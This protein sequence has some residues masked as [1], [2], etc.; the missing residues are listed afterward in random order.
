[1][2]SDRTFDRAQG[3]LGIGLAPAVMKVLCLAIV[4]GVL[5]LCLLT[6]ERTGYKRNAAKQRA[7]LSERGTRYKQLARAL[8]ALVRVRRYLTHRLTLAGQFPRWPR[9]Q[10]DICSLSSLHTRLRFVDLPTH[11]PREDAVSRDHILRLL[12]LPFSFQVRLAYTPRARRASQP[13]RPLHRRLGRWP[14]LAA[15]AQEAPGYRVHRGFLRPGCGD[16]AMA[17]KVAAAACPSG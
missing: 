8:G 10:V 5:V 4:L 11:R 2:Q 13:A 3:G 7:E 1:V 9:P 6:A 14:P 12:T 15:D 17:L 16:R